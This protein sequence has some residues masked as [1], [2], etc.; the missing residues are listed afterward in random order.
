MYM[1]DKIDFH[2]QANLD[3]KLKAMYCILFLFIWFSML[4]ISC[5]I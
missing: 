2:S 5:V 4:I 1:F 3:S